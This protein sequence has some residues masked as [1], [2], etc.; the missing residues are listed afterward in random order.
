MVTCKE[1]KWATEYVRS[2]DNFGF[3]TKNVAA[4]VFVNFF[5]ANNPKFDHTKF[6]RACGFYDT[7][8]PKE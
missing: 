7:K 3:I 6:Y 8:S 1:M 4:Q 2:L 5:V